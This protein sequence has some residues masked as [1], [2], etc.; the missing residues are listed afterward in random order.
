[1]RIHLKCRAILISGIFTKRCSVMT[2][3]NVFP[4]TDGS[5]FLR[6]GL[7]MEVIRKIK[8]VVYVRNWG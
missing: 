2:D 7:F 6:L 3:M 1:M 8:L 4:C 5:I